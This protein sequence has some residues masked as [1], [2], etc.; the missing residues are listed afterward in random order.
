MYQEWIFN[1][2]SHQRLFC[3]ISVVNCLNLIIDEETV[4][5]ASSVI[6]AQFHLRPGLLGRFSEKSEQQGEFAS[7]SGFTAFSFHVRMHLIRMTLAFIQKEIGIEMGSAQRQ[8][9]FSV[10]Q[11]RVLAFDWNVL[12]IKVRANI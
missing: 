1:S 3:F 12:N 11:N 9:P 8:I 4:K 6:C 10:E 5:N 2:H 7:V